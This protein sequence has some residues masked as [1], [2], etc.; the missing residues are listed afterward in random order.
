[1]EKISKISC[2]YI[3]GFIDGEGYIGLTRRGNSF[4]PRVTIANCNLGVLKSIQA[5]IGGSIQTKPR[6]EGTLQGYH[7]AVANFDEWLPSIV[8]YLRGKKKKAELLLE[9]VRMLGKRQ[10]KTG[11]AHSLFLEELGVIDKRL[12][13]K[14][15]EV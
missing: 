9:A 11:G 7:L 13:L 15:W 5:E 6:R 3:A 1:M 12:R 2:A 10:K 4:H 14:E 8:P